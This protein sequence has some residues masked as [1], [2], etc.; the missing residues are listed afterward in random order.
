MIC[1]HTYFRTYVHRCIHIHILTYI[2]IV[3]TLQTQIQPQIRISH[4]I[5]HYAIHLYQRDNEDSRY[6]EDKP[7]VANQTELR[8]GIVIKRRSVIRI[9][10]KLNSLSGQ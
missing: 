9:T 1:Y 2:R 6:D 5:E 7:E 8:N 4:R 10:Q 3:H